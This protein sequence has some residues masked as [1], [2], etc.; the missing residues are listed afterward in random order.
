MLS[1]QI[2]L[3]KLYNRFHDENE[4]DARIEKLRE[5]QR[6]LDRLVVEAYGWQ[7]V[8]LDHGFHEV[9]YLVEGDKVRYTICEPARIE[10]LRRLAT[11]NHERY[12]AQE[13]A[14]AAENEK[15]NRGRNAK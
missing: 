1:D 15:G 10:I 14:K 12:E 8:E 11:L 5:M 7:D 6:E 9:G 2:G 4:T 13:A 3:T